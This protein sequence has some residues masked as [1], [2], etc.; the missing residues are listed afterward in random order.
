MTV[1]TFQGAKNEF[2]ETE[3]YVVNHCRGNYLLKEVVAL[4][5]DKIVTTGT[6]VSLRKH[7]AGPG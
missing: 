5:Q 7:H 2:P 6:S 4:S 3:K 1:S